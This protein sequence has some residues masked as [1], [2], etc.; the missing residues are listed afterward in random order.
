MLRIKAEIQKNEI[1]TYFI[2]A[3]GKFRLWILTSFIDSK[4]LKVLTYHFYLLK[5]RGHSGT[6]P[7]FLSI[8]Q[9]L[10]HSE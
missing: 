8:L 7:T 4:E 1:Y 5:S 9:S 2:I 10:N 3:Q 6:V